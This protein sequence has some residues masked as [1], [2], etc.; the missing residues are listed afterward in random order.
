MQVAEA[1]A[2]RHLLRTSLTGRPSS[3]KYL[4]MQPILELNPSHSLIRYL[5]QLVSSEGPKQVEDHILATA[6]IDY[7]LDAGMAHA[8]LLDEAREMVSRSSQLLTLLSE[9]VTATTGSGGGTKL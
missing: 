6:L 5:Y 3:E 9:R 8:G 2:M 4:V 1:G 7:L